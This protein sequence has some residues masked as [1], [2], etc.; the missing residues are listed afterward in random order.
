MMNKIFA[1]Y[2]FF[3][4]YVYISDKFSKFHITSQETDLSILQTIYRKSFSQHL[5]IG[6]RRD[7][8]H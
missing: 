2:I 1:K 5:G 8:I 7:I 4:I 6:D 3:Y